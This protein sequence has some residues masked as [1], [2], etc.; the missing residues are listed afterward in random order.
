MICE[1]CK[2]ERPCWFD[3]V[4]KHEQA[5]HPRFHELLKQIGDLHNRKNKDYAEGMKEGPLGNFKRVSAIMKNY[6]EMDWDSPLGVSIIYSLKQLDAAL[7]LRSTKKQSVTGEP[8]AARLT[9]IAIY[10]L[11]GIILEEEEPKV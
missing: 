6:P 9:D 10:A 1:I 2:Q 3:V 11:L 4:T 8:I 7:T 5:G